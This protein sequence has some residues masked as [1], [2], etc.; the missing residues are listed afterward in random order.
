MT[1]QQTAHRILENVKFKS[2]DKA[3]IWALREAQDALIKRSPSKVI[4]DG[5]GYADGSIVYDMA[6]C[7]SCDYSF[8]DNDETWEMP[9]CPN[10]GQALDWE[11]ES[12]AAEQ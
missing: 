1:D 10:C 2:K 4:Y 6:H 7:P 12:E 3:E 9:F 5:D 11:T 8:E